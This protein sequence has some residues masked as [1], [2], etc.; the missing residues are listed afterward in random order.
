MVNMLPDETSF[1]ALD[2]FEFLFPLWPESRQGFFFQ[3]SH[4]SLFQ[5]SAHPDSF[6]TANTYN[7][8]HDALVFAESEALS[9]FHPQSFSS[10]VW[11][12]WR[13]TRRQK[14]VVVGYIASLCLL[15]IKEQLVNIGSGGKGDACLPVKLMGADVGIWAS[16]KAFVSLG[17]PRKKE[18]LLFTQ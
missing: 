8:L 6:W 9:D 3:A 15:S 4:R 2:P 14:Y 11:R 18:I 7:D 5:R 12:G 13:T 16:S 17:A 1:S 10:G